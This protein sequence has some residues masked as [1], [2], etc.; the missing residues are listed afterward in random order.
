MSPSSA[1]HGGQYDRHVTFDKI[2]QAAFLGIKKECGVY[3]G[4]AGNKLVQ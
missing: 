3:L 2:M 4:P 1:S